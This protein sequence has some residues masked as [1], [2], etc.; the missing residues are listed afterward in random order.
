MSSKLWLY[1]KQNNITGLKYFGKTTREDPYKY[2]GSGSYWLRH[3][4][5]HGNDVSTIKVWSFDDQ[6]ECERFALDFSEKNNIV[7]SKEWANLIPENSKS[8]KS[9]GSP[10]LKGTSN[11]QYGKKQHLN[12]FYGKKHSKKTLKH[13]SEVKTGGKNPRAKKVITPNGDFS[14][15][16]D[17]AKAEGISRDTMRKWINGNKLGYQ[18]DN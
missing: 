8:G 6:L 17:A 16:A 2:I 15:L 18:W 5:K 14:C 3:L 1:I 4:K 10:G 9:V 12:S 7:E 11:P 13:L